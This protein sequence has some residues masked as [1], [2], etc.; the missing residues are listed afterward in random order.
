MQKAED[1]VFQTEATM[2]PRMSWRV[3]LEHLKKGEPSRELLQNE[4]GEEWQE[5]G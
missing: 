5:I 1:Q 2:R 3:N 4:L